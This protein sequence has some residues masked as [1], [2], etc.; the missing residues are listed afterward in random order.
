MRY[1]FGRMN[2]K[3]YV[4]ILGSNPA[5]SA[6]E[7]FSV[8]YDARQNTVDISDDV[9]LVKGE[10]IAP[11][12]INNLGGTIKIAEVI[13]QIP[14]NN[15]QPQ[16]IIGRVCD[17]IKGQN[18]SD[19]KKY[20]VG[21]SIYNLG[22]S[23]SFLNR[24]VRSIRFFYVNIKKE[25]AKNGQKIAF[26][27][28]KGNTLNSASVLKNDLLKENGSEFIVISSPSVIYLA[29]TIAVQD[30]DEY[31]KRDVGRPKRDLV[32]GTTPPKLAKL[33]INLA[34]VKKGTVLDPFCGSGTFLQE[35]ALLGFEKIYGSDF[36]QK[37][38]EDTKENINWLKNE[39][40]V[41][42]SI[43]VNLID[44]LKLG[45]SYKPSSIDAIVSEVY[46]GPPLKKSLES[47]E[48]E[49]LV[50]DL[51]AMYQKVLEE[52]AKVL[53]S[54]G[55]VVL[56]LPIF[57]NGTRLTLL[58]ID[59]AIKASGFVAVNQKEGMRGKFSNLF[60]HRGSIIYSRPDQL[61][62]REILVLKK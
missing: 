11:Q 5:L 39:F 37:A 31:T 61:V 50:S 58:Q 7:V 55:T 54:D 51:S 12:T 17:Y 8:F 52:I 53:K 30:V 38:I 47:A 25:C 40:N 21:I 34:G 45:E 15:Y 20:H 42:S 33:M 16:E 6:S 23:K 36:S 1:N 2:N 48:Q 9:L 18:I 3:Q 62:L 10:E 56:A 57:K 29:K 46:L 49:K 35:M 27:N 59:D 60:T 32:S 26:L 14:K 4:Y 41:K 22:G 28:T 44:A 43:E 24:L 13:S 19:S